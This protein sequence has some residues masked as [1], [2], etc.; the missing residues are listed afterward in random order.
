MAVTEEA[1]FC[2]L[3]LLELQAKRIPDAPAILAPGRAPLTYGGLH[4]HVGEMERALRALGIGPQDRMAVVLPNGPA[5]AVAILTVA[6]S[7]VCAPLNPAYGADEVDR[8]SLTCARRALR[9][10]AGLDSPARRVAAAWGLRIVEL[11]AA[12]DDEAGLFTLGG[13]TSGRALSHGAAGPGDV[14]LLLLTSGTTSRPKVVPLT[15]A[16][17]WASARASRVALALTERDSCLNVLPLFHGHGLIATIMASLEAGASAVYPKCGQ[18]LGLADRVPADMV[19]G[20]P[21]H[22]P[23]DPRPGRPPP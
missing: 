6:A 8:Y 18:L 13:D 14:A 22:A 2:L 17:I 19:L 10:Q 15:H 12:P 16:N 1:P 11:S 7:A 23:G 20:G 5:M 21:H 9:T 3:P 4:Q